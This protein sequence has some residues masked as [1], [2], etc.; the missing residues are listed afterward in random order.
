MLSER[1]AAEYCGLSARRFAFEC[2]VK[3]VEM[4]GGV[5]LFDI[6]DLDDWIDH[7]KRDSE[8]TSAETLLARL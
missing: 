7:L 2:P 8:V 6:R 3:P 5:K 4:P 1:D